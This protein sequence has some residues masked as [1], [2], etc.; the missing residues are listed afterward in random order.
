MRNVRNLLWMPP[1]GPFCLGWQANLRRKGNTAATAALSTN[2]NTA[3]LTIEGTY[4]VNPD[5]TGT[6]TV[7]M[8]PLGATVHVDFVI[9][10]GGT[11]LRAIVTFTGVVESRVYTKQPRL[12]RN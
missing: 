2:R 6:M 11:A 12:G 9:S 8:S 4:T 1:F 5:S 10:E 3:M 7:D